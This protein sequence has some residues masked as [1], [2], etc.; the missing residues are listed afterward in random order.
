MGICQIQPYVSR[1]QLHSLLVSF[2]LFFLI[3]LDKTQSVTVLQMIQLIKNNLVTFGPENNLI[4][5][6]ELKCP[7]HYNYKKFQ[8]WSNIKVV[9]FYSLDHQLFFHFHTADSP[10]RRVFSG[11]I[12]PWDFFWAY[13]IQ[14]PYRH[15]LQQLPIDLWAV[16]TMGPMPTAISEKDFLPT[17]FSFYSIMPGSGLGYSFLPSCSTE[18]N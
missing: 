7:I 16:R 9:L 12:P 15:F 18:K 11:P 3:F 10:F 5:I 8:I 6:L 4:F 17:S 1:K 13:P 14:L 2:K